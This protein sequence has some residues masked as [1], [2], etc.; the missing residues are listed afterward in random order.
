M[1]INDMPYSLTNPKYKQVD[2][3]SILSYKNTLLISKTLVEY[4][5]GVW[6]YF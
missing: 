4:H 3:T 1:S 6:P 2:T 5:I